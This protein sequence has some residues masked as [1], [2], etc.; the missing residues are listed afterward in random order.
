MKRKRIENLKIPILYRLQIY[1]K[2]GYSIR[3]IAK[4][5]QTSCDIISLLL[6]KHNLWPLSPGEAFA[7]Q[8]QTMLAD[9]KY[10][11]KQ[12]AENLGISRK[13][14]YNYINRLNLRQNCKVPWGTTW[15]NWKKFLPSKPKHLP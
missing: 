14:L 4:Q 7:A 15:R 12:V 10:T 13:T 6:R 8:I 9:K 2:N 5:E 1:C 3:D 11:M